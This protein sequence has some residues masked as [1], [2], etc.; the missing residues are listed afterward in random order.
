MTN[1]KGS[2]LGMLTFEQRS[3]AQQAHDAAS[4][5]DTVT[6]VLDYVVRHR[7]GT[8]GL[9][10]LASALGLQQ[11]LEELAGSVEEHLERHQR[12]FDVRKAIAEEDGLALDVGFS[13]DAASDGQ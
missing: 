10:R 11:E 12:L 3:L 13:G 2:P 1:R 6:V 4:R 9:L 8:A 7:L 5:C